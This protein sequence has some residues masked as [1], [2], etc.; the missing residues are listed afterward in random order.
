M[1]DEN[2]TMGMVGGQR[3]R[4]EEWRHLI[5]GPG[6][7]FPGGAVDF[8]M[9]LIK[10]SVQ[11]GFDFKLLK[12]CKSRVTAVCA[13]REETGCLW[14]IHAVLDSVDQAF[15]ISMYEHNHTCGTIFGTASRKRINYHIITEI[16]MEDVRAM[17]MLSPVQVKA[18]VKK[19]Y[20]V[21]ISYSV[22]WKAMD[23]GEI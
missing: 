22:V 17:P 12:N 13:K 10:Y 9:A 20:G 18:M 1:G 2:G 16:I 14:R 5:V 4:S 6:Q 23:G 11:V 15:R 19:N 7:R 3:L 8:R 21:E